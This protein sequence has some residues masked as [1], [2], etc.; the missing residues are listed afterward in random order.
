[1]RRAAPFLLSLAAVGGLAF[2]GGGFDPPAWGWAGIGLAWAAAA[3]LVLR[4]GPALSR[5]EGLALVALAAYV[6]WAALSTVWTAS[7]PLTVL[8]AQRLLV[9]PLGLATFLA[10]G[11]AVGLL[12]GVAAAAALASAWNLVTRVGAGGD[13]GETAQPLG[14]GNAVGILAGIGLLLALGLARERPAWLLASVPT[15][16]ALLLSQSR[17]AVLA[18]GVGAV[19]VVALRSGAARV[20]LPLVLGAG[21]AVLAAAA[22]VASNERAAYWGT[23]AEAIAERPLLGGGSGAWV[24]D[25]LAHRDEL[26]PARDAHSLY[27]ETLAELGP[28][29]LALV[30]VALLAPLVAA[31]RAR[32]APHV[33]V[34]GGAYAA[35]VLH[36]GVDW[37]LELPAV[38]LAG[39]ACGAFLLGAEPAP[40]RPLPRR[41]AFA[42]LGAA[43]L[44]AA[45]GL[46]GN[47]FVSGAAGALRGGDYA[48]AEERAATA[49]RL[50]PWSSEAWRLRGEAQRAL[51][52]SAAAAASFREGLERDAGD[53]ELWL[54]LARVEEGE[55]RRR[56]LERV[57]RLNPLGLSS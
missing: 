7:V 20:L 31:P 44:A 55:G 54:A 34:A 45:V 15:A 51:G 11:A 13:L 24:R 43:G 33:P 25:W 5:L 36:A 38:A 10:V 47:S 40:R 29:G 49:T 39:L 32:T 19:A 9:L 56:A 3:G 52:D 18:V 14:Y 26:V 17:G 21:A 2:A 42:V 27:L 6:A 37:D 48:R 1:V 28:L 22:L 30:V 41:P 4:G 57:R 12:E 46:A 50:A 53:V 16:G 8:D 35:F 23:T